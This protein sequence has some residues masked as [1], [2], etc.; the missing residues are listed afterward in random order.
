M[1]KQ[2]YIIFIAFFLMSCGNSSKDTSAKNK[3]KKMQKIQSSLNPLSSSIKNEIAVADAYNINSGKE[4][5]LGMEW[6][7]AVSD[8]EQH[9]LDFFQKNHCQKKQII[10]NNVYT[11]LETSLKNKV[12]Q[13]I[14]DLQNHKN[15][16]STDNLFLNVLALKKKACLLSEIEE[17][18]KTASLESSANADF[19]MSRYLPEFN[20][21]TT[22]MLRAK[23]YSSL[24]DLTKEQ[25]LFL[26]YNPLFPLSNPF[27]YASNFSFYAS[28]TPGSP[29]EKISQLVPHI[30]DENL[31]IAQ[32]FFKMQNME[33]QHFT[34]L[35]KENR[36][37]LIDIII[38][39]EFL[40]QWQKKENVDQP[41]D[42]RKLER[43][44][45][46]LVR[47]ESL[48]RKKVDKAVKVLTILNQSLQNIQKV[49]GKYFSAK[50]VDENGSEYIIDKTNLE[51]ILKKVFTSYSFPSQEKV[52]SNN[53]EDNWN[54]EWNN[55]ETGISYEHGF[56]PPT[57]AMTLENFLKQ[58]M[59]SDENSKEVKEFFLKA[60]VTANGK[61]EFIAEM[62]LNYEELDEVLQQTKQLYSLYDK[63][64]KLVSENKSIL[65]KSSET[66]NKWANNC[67]RVDYYKIEEFA[68]TRVLNAIL[69][70]QETEKRRNYY[71]ELVKKSFINFIQETNLNNETKLSIIERIISVQ[72]EKISS[73]DE[74]NI[75]QHYKTILNAY[76]EFKN[77]PRISEKKLYKEMSYSPGFPSFIFWSEKEVNAY[78]DPISHSIG[79]NAPYLI[80][81]A[82][83]QYLLKTLTVMAHEIG[84]AIDPL[85]V[86]NVKDKDF[87][88]VLKYDQLYAMNSS[89]YNFF[90]QQ[91][92]SCLNPSSENKYYDHYGED[93]ADS[94]SLE[95][96]D[97]M[98]KKGNLKNLNS[99]KRNIYFQTLLATT[100]ETS[101]SSLYDTH[102]SIKDRALRTLG[103]K[104]FMSN[105]RNDNEIKFF[106][107]SK[108]CS[109]SDLSKIK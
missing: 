53:V 30:P 56:I 48:Y 55:S 45:N 28:T 8:F 72:L 32:E 66:E 35:N 15:L 80:D 93:F 91:Y 59:I 19:E 39:E 90:R 52:D 89:G 10:Q 65:D 64:E 85:K 3:Q 23:K 96:V 81:E 16:D 6:E 27:G 58:G 67:D 79:L 49:N 38:A 105:I 34:I 14:N 107:D 17:K 5:S 86:E 11:V 97:F 71:F 37:K 7:N 18:T 88:N 84:H 82:Y 100:C 46:N 12:L 101:K 22:Q 13:K 1:K 33:V 99:Y 103:N 47:N 57:E 94:F 60:L 2:A 51:T 41:I 61:E 20:N 106:P 77:D 44:L 25:A 43:Q 42:F 109:V 31:E 54:L 104:Q 108:Q 74:K 24:E 75:Y 76:E 63:M 26:I 73:E 102:G 70:N 29:I 92:L 98:L 9:G 62:L 21:V 40:E 87:Q 4:I 68:L 95:V 78:Y 36:Q 50:L 69:S 83:D